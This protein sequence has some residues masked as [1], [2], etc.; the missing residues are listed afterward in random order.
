LPQ[1]VDGSCRDTNATIQCFKAGETRVNNNLGLVGLHTLFLREH[2]RVATKLQL[3]NPD[4]SDDRLFNEARR[5]VIAEYQHMVFTQ[6]L[7]ALIGQNFLKAFELDSKENGEYYTGY[8]QNVNLLYL[9]RNKIE[10]KI[11]NYFKIKGQSISSK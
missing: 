3:I 2:N 4:W 10:F 6:Y 5:I 7:P 8:N 9:K 1:T 11:Q